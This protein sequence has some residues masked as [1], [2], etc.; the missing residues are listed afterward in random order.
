MSKQPELTESRFDRESPLYA[1]KEIAG[2]VPYSW[3]YVLSIF[4]SH[5]REII[6]ANSVAIIAALLSVP[7][8]L[9]MPLLVDEVLLNQPGSMLS[10]LDTLMPS[11]ITGPATYIA[12]VLLVTI[13]L[14]LTSMAL[15]VWQTRKFSLISKDLI[16]RMR[17]ELIERLERVS[18]SEYETLGSST[19]SSHLVVDLNTVDEFTGVTVSRLLIAVLMLIGAAAVLMWMHWPL[20]L[21]ILVMNPIS[22]YL[23][24]LISKRVKELKRREN[25]ALQIFSES[26]SETLDAIHQIRAANRERHYLGRVTDLA[27]EIRGHSA[28]Y[29]WKSDAASRLSFVVFLIGIDAFRATAMLMVIF[30]DLSLGRMIAVFSYLWFML[31]PIETILGLQYAYQGATA[32]L[33]RINSLFELNDEPSYVHRSDPFSGCRANGLRLVDL[34]FRYGDGSLIIDGLNLDVVSGEKVAIVGASG[35]GKSTLVQ[36]ILGL[37]KPESGSIFFDGVTVQDI[38][39]DIVRENVGTVLQHPALLH[40][41]V[42]ENLTMGRTF[43]DRTLWEALEIA[44]LRSVVTA[45][46]KQLETIVGRSGVRLSGG[47]RQRLAIARM[48]LAEPNIV[49]LD[50]A[51]SALDVAT[52]AAMHE[53]LHDRLADRT[54]IVIAHRLSAVRHAD[55]VLV[56]EAGRVAEEGGHEELIQ[57]RG[58]YARLYGKA[59]GP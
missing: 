50:E 32:A 44:Q 19:V 35:G 22:I 31:G 26:L 18:M 6:F 37:Y 9:L 13:L 53:A 33:D 12:A 10:A 21:F 34:R 16:Y 55:R 41:S 48:L 59:Q 51:T 47:Q 17:S 15:Q 1:P 11:A 28:A 54:M 39:L 36:I 8:P 52:E 5:R 7:V 38:G 27:R 2:R 57:K 42:R 4:L 3:H 46:P 30:S 43:D 23:T 29:A 24:L 56:L 58:L 20:G 25:K 45:Q 14:R 40:A 49:I